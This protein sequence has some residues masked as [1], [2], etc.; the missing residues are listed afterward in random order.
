MGGREVGEGGSLN[1]LGQ[2]Q[3]WRVDE[4]NYSGGATV[5]EKGAVGRRKEGKEVR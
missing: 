3:H 1:D 5:T 2:W 4:H